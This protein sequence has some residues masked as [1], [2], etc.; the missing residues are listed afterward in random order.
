M[1]FVFLNSLPY[2]YLLIIFIANLPV[3]LILLNLFLSFLHGFD[4]QVQ[5]MPNVFK[6][7]F[8]LLN[9]LYLFIY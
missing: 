8:R 1:Q 2:C 4:K 5:I 7:M 3:A 9:P 6:A